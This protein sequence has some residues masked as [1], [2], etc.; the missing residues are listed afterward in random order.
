MGNIE[1]LT[2]HSNKKIKGHVTI[3]LDN[4]QETRVIENENTFYP[5]NIQRY[6]YRWGGVDWAYSYDPWQ[7]V[8]GIFLFDKTI[9]NGKKYMPAGTKMTGNACID[10]TNNG[11][12]AELGTFVSKSNTAHSME[13]NYLWDVSHG[14]G[15]INSVSLTSRVGGYIGYGNRSNVRASTV[16]NLI[17]GSTSM[18]SRIDGDNRYGYYN[19]YVYRASVDKDTNTFNVY[20]IPGDLDKASIFTQSQLVSTHQI[21]SD[22]TYI[23]ST[24]SPKYFNGKIYMCSFTYQPSQTYN[25]FK[26]QVGSTFLSPLFVYDIETDTL[27]EYQLVNDTGNVIEF[28]YYTVYDVESADP[29]ENIIRY[30]GYNFNYLTGVDSTQWTGRAFTP[31]LYYIQKENIHQGRNYTFSIYDPVNETDYITN[32]FYYHT[33]GYK[34]Y[35]DSADGFI[36]WNNYDANDDTI[37]FSNPLYLA[38]ISNLQEPVTKTDSDILQLKYVLTDS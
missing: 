4:G 36:G 9:Q 6:L 7:L 12:P 5:E 8:G 35:D 34:Q 26:W 33:N 17:T 38:T 3:K 30:A 10:V 24:Q 28:S 23:N 18:D 13:F 22:T 19:G 15:I 2:P 27:S 32:G 16:Y 14:N 29:K 20:R 31:E 11:V 25:N 37:P 1:I 21:Q